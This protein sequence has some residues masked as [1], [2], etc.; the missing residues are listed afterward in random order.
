MS[1]WEKIGESDEWYTPKFIFDALKLQFDLDVASPGVSHWVPALK[2]F[3]K[4]DD[5]LKQP[6]I[7][8]V[9]MNPPFGGRNGQVPWIEKFVKHGDGI[10]IIAARTSAKWFQ[11]LVPLCD[12]ICFPRGKTKF[13]RPDGSVGK[14]PGSGIAIVAIG[15]KSTKK[16]QESNLGIFYKTWK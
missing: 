3:T 10:A 1:E 6:W 2:V 14:S 13:I 16:L 5:G 12:A 7:G 8:T 9:F 4:E 11:D 15:D